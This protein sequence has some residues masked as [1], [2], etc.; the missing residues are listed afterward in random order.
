LQAARGSIVER[1]GTM[2]TP[3]SGLARAQDIG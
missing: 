3:T 1:D 2:M